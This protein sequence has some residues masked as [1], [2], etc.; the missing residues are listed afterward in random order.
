MNEIVPHGS[1]GWYI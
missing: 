1:E